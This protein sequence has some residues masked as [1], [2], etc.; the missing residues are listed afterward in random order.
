MNELNNEILPSVDDLLAGGGSKSLSFKDFTVGD[1]YTGTISGLRTVQV[2]NYDD[3][4]KLEFWDDGKPKLQ[5]EVTLDTDYKDATDDEDTGE[6]RVFLFG[7]KL[8]AAKEEMKRKGMAKLEIGSE[9]TITLT[10]TKPAKN[11]RYN[12][13]KLYGIEL[14]PSTSNPAVDAL[15]SAGATE[16]KSAKIEALDAKQ[17]KVAETLQSNGFTAAEIAEQ[18]GV[19]VSA[20]ESVLTF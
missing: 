9:F 4:T 14:K 19:S 20:V 7:Q 3:P 16:V 6:R 12:D 13:V 5:I 1:S 2:R 15:L 8:T 11:P 17:T 10:G 18:L